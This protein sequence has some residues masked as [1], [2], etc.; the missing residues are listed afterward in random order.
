MTIP[1]QNPAIGDP[2]VGPTA[3]RVE[4][5]ALRALH[6]VQKLN[7][8]S[9]EQILVVSLGRK[10]RPWRETDHVSFEVWKVGDG[11]V[12]KRVCCTVQS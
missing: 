8:S 7:L 3:E 6:L 1:E 9:L 10:L 11:A 4:G 5:N 2:S 12:L